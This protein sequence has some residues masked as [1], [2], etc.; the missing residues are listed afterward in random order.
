MMA[1]EPVDRLDPLE[2]PEVV[3]LIVQMRI[4]DV[5]MA[6]LNKIDQKSADDLHALHSEG[7]ILGSLPFIDIREDEQA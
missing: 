1:N 3:Q 7:K 4:Y 5:L 2:N 6:I